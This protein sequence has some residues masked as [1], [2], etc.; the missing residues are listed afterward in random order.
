V[1]PHAPNP[2]AA[3][4]WKDEFG[5]EAYQ[6]L[7]RGITEDLRVD[8]VVLEL[9]TLRMANNAD[10]SRVEHMVVAAFVRSIE[11]G[12]NAVEHKQRVGVALKRWGALLGAL[13]RNNMA[14][15]LGRL[16]VR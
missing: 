10:M 9:K 11:L 1:E 2:W 14:T 13:C 16:Q 12:Q 5:S 4:R 8:D 15:A 7:Q 3:L 6:T